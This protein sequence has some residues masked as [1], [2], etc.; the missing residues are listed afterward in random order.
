MLCAGPGAEPRLDLCEHYLESL[1]GPARRWHRDEGG[2]DL[3]LHPWHH[4]YPVDAVLRRLQ[5]GGELA[6]GR[7]L[8]TLL[9]RRRRALG[10]PSLRLV[11][12]L[13][14]NFVPPWNLIR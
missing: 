2:F 8:G 13:H 3:L 4:A 7:A 11:L 1:P 10:A 9:G 12:P 14:A 5:F 6:Y